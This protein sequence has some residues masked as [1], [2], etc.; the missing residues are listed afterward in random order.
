MTLANSDVIFPGTY[1]QQ[2]FLSFS[3]IFCHTILLYIYILREK[4]LAIIHNGVSH[5]RS[6]KYYIFLI[7]RFENMSVV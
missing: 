2:H 6:L 1:K 5:R 3:Y 7:G 4:S